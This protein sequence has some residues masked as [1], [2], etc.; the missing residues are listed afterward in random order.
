MS[1]KHALPSAA[2]ALLFAAAVG[3][4]E[5]KDETGMQKQGD[6]MGQQQS[7][8][9]LSFE[10]LDTDRD[11]YLSQREVQQK[12]DMSEPRQNRPS[13]ATSTVRRGRLPVR[14]APTGESSA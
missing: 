13:A 6:T 9:Q 10:K 11:G 14:A 4:A 8:G 7:M 2:V 12:S 1:V 5:H 3:A